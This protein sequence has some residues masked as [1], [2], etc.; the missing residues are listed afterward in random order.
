VT[1]SCSQTTESPAA[2]EGSGRRLAGSLRAGDLLLLAGDLASGKTTFVR[3]LLTGLGGDP[4]EV[5]RRPRT[6]PT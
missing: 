6:C 5:A 4:E 1:A 2:T 3:G